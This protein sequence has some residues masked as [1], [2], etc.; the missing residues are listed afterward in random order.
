MSWFGRE[1]AIPDAP[2]TVRAAL[3]ESPWVLERLCP[4]LARVA[5]LQVARP[6]QF[7]SVQPAAGGLAYVIPTVVKGGPPAAENGLPLIPTDVLITD[8]VG[9]TW[10]TSG[11]M[12]VMGPKALAGL[13]PGTD[14]SE[15]TS[16][17][18]CS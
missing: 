1:L 8:R 13:R 14:C 2:A 10:T 15:S 5:Y 12:W 18:L 17:R 7:R 11:G 6:G 4:A 3:N 9:P 16:R